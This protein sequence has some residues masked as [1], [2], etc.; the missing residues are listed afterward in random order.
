MRGVNT[1]KETAE[2]EQITAIVGEYGLLAIFVMIALEYACFPMPSEV[3]LP[4]AGAI[5]WQGGLGFFPVLLCSVLA[6]V[7]GSYI[8]YGIGAYGGRALIN[9]MIRRFPKT[10]KG[11]T[12]AQKKFDSC[13]VLSVAVCRVIPL[14]R[15]YISFI[16]GI[17]RQNPWVFGLSSLSGIVVWNTVLI[18]LGYLFS[19]HW[20]DISSYYAQYKTVIFLLIGL[21]IVAK[22]VHRWVIRRSSRGNGGRLERAE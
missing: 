11:L 10:E 2:M 12:A 9:G 15:T 22:L 14:C 8:C 18:G 17:G 16:A 19:D 21:I 3:L 7:T 4:L 1:R 5:A 13:S 6:G 20:K